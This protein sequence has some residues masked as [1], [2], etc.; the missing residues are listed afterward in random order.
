MR[1]II[2][3]LIF[4]TGFF[5]FSQVKVGNNPNTIDINS[6]LEL[7]SSDKVFVITRINSTQMNAIAPLEGSLVYNTDLKC[8]FQYNG[9]IWESLCSPPSSGSGIQQLSFNSTTNELTLQNGGTVNLSSLITDNDSDP[10]NELQDLRLNGNLLTITNNSSTTSVDLSSFLDNTDDQNIDVLTF[11]TTNNE[12]TVGIEGG[13]D[14]T[15]D[16]SAL[17]SDGSETIVNVAGINTISGTGTT[18]DPY[19]ITGTEVD[20]SVTNETNTTFAVNAGNLEI[21]DSNGT[22]SV[23]L[24]ALGTDDQNIDVLTFNT[25][26]NEL[27]VGIE[28]GT[29]LTVDLSDLVSSVATTAP[30]GGLTGRTIATHTANG[31]T[32]TI[33]ESVTTLTQDDTPSSTDPTATGEI[34]YTNES[35]TTSTAQV[36]AAEADNNI[37]VGANGGAYF[38]G[39]VI[40]SAGKVNANGTAANVYNATIT[41]LTSNNGGGGPEGDYQVTFST[42]L[43]TG[44]I[45]VIQ[46]TIPDCGGD[47]PGN[48][49][50]NYDDPG[51]TYYA[52]NENGFRVNIKDSDNGTTQGD[53]ID[54]D[55]M[56]TVIRLP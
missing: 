36:V 8:I 52:Q 45:Y 34:T 17:V 7:E 3:L 16:L 11:N 9:S 40:Y 1:K 29:D 19:I 44:T 28:G 56:F 23:P 13:T 31:T 37:K 42:P 35:G 10:T 21:T 49:N 53:D 39:P 33:Q 25:T 54:L 48:S 38:A 26:N 51:I 5:A 32:T 24:T 43:P 20:G 47:C 46:L 4:L 15:V 50:A 22:L 41:K 2:T 27:T 6:I 18:A 14:L 30:V 12:L 55:F